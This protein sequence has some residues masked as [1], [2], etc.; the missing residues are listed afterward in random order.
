MGAASDFRGAFQ[1]I[2]PPS[3][4][5]G[6][7]YRIAANVGCGYLA[8]SRTGAAALLVPLDAAASGVGRRGGGFALTPV[9]SVAFNYDGRSWIQAAAVLECTEPSL[10]DTFFVLVGDLAERLRTTESIGRWAVTLLWLEDWQ[11]LL[12]RRGVMT[13]EQQLGLWGELWFLSRSHKVD[14][15]A[16]GWRGPDSEAID[17]FFDGVGLEIKVSRRPHVHHLSRRQAEAPVGGFAA[18]L[19][20]IWIAPEPA[21]GISLVDLVDE[22]ISTVSDPPLFLRR[23]SRLGYSVQDRDQYGMKYSLLEKPL[24]FDVTDVP[25]IRSVDEG[26]SEVRYTVVLDPAKALVED[27]TQR[28]CQ[29]FWNPA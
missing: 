3:P 16:A 21:R 15:L 8:R 5:S 7:D 22:L 28:L 14:S 20:S 11:A 24:W 1:A 10:I 13:S 25:R 9:A 19:L 4:S 29:H 18:Y 12:V 2:G 23:L 26:I 27:A 6:D 17:F